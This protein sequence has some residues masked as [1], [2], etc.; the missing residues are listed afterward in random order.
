MGSRRS[1]SQRRY[2]VGPVSE[3]RA[4]ARRSVR[5]TK[6][7][8]S[9]TRLDKSVGGDVLKSNKDSGGSQPRLRYRPDRSKLGVVPIES[10]NSRTDWSHTGI[11]LV[12]SHNQIQQ[13][14][15]V[16]RAR[17][18]TQ[19]PSGENPLSQMLCS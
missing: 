19:W 15:S 2:S 8:T 6:S 18:I 12:R 7:S 1:K 5:I 10:L 14:S 3:A 16:L 9:A 17:M 11:P 4:I 13:R